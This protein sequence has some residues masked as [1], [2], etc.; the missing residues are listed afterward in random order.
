MVIGAALVVAAVVIGLGAFIVHRREK[1]TRP[2]HA[3]Q[4]GFWCGT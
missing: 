2:P 1:A 3:Y 4:R